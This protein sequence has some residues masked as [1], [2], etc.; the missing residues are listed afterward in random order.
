MGHRTALPTELKELIRLIRQG[1]LFD[2]QK[3]IRNGKSIR[4]P[5]EGHFILSP[6]LAAVRTG[7]HSLVEVLLDELGKEENLEDLLYEAVHL[8]RLDLVELLH[9]FGANPKAISY[10]AVA[11]THHPLIL[12]WF[13]DHGVDLETDQPLAAAFRWRL[14]GALGTYMR[15][16]DRMPQLRYQANMALR[17]HAG[18]GDLK[19]V[20][21]LLWA[22]AD[23]RA[24]VPRIGTEC[25]EESKGTALQTAVFHGHLEVVRKFKITAKDVSDLLHK[26]GWSENRDLVEL[27]LE[28][29]A[30]PSSGDENSAVESYVQSLGWA[31]EGNSPFRRDPRAL[32]DILCLFAAKGARWNPPDKYRYRC[33]RKGLARANPEEAIEVLRKLVRAGF[34]SEATFKELVSTPRMRQLLSS[35]RYGVAQLREFAG[36]QEPRK[37]RKR[38]LHSCGV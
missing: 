30:D 38:R 7:F 19:W 16:K 18:K 28:L 34:F 11:S 2:V 5:K 26:S 3:W 9:R 37:R 14:R 8:R 23:P 35:G 10:D 17:F 32:T 20:S 4:L 27:L 22:G 25:P 29:G 1:R 15:W 31:L 6:L 21:L 36:F 13:E 24:V 12:R 33:F